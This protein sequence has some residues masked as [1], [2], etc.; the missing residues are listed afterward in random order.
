MRDGMS[1]NVLEVKK[2][3]FFCLS[4][5]FIIINFLTFVIFIG[6]EIMLNYG[7]KHMKARF[8]SFTFIPIMYSLT[9]LSILITGLTAKILKSVK[10]FR[11]VFWLFIYNKYVIVSVCIVALKIIIAI[12]IILLFNN[13]SKI[14]I[15][16]IEGNLKDYNIYSQNRIIQDFIQSTFKCCGVYWPFDYLKFDHFNCQGGICGVPTSCCLNMIDRNCGVNVLDNKKT[17]LFL[18]VTKIHTDGC[19]KTILTYMSDFNFKFVIAIVVTI[20]IGFQTNYHQI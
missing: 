16:L 7:E 19:A 3:A 20:Y 14:L 6:L 17:N 8:G 4:V 2:I 10:I 11:L 15:Y 5:L 1:L 12:V 13:L 18:L 9:T